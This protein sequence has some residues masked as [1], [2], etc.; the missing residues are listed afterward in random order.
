MFY[1]IYFDCDL[2]RLLI[3]VRRAI[4]IMFDGVSYLLLAEIRGWRAMET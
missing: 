1:E 4:Y 3:V 2:F